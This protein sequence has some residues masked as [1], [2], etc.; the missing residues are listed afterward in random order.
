MRVF[1]YRRISRVTERTTSIE[2]QGEHCTA[3]C[4]RRGWKVVDDFSDEG[5]S[6]ATDPEDRP[7][8]ARMLARLDEV[9]AIVFYKLDRLSRST[10]AFAELMERCKA[11]GVALVSCTEPLDLSSPMGVA[12]AEIIAVFAKLER[13]MIRER[14]MDA[15]RKGLEDHKF[16]GGRFP[17]GL[18]PAPH[19]SGKGR[20]LV[21]DTEAVKN[22]RRMA[23]LV[24]AGHSASAIARKLNEDK[25]PTSRQQGATAKRAGGHEARDTY[26]RGNAVRAILRNQVQLGYRVGKNERP[27]TGSDGLPLVIWEPVL[28]WE[29]WEAVQTAIDA[30]EVTR[31]QRHDAHWLQG[32]T[33]CGVCDARLTQTVAH[34]RTGLKCARPNEERHKPAPFIRADD[35]DAWVNEQMTTVYGRMRVIENVWHSGS[36]NRQERLAVASAI[37]AMRADRKAGLY[38][39]AEDEAEYTD[40]ITS[41]LARRDVLDATPET[42]PHWETR[43]TGRTFGDV[44]ESSTLTARAALMANAGLVVRV[45]PAGGKRRPVGERARIEQEDPAA[46]ELA[47]SV[48]DDDDEPARRPVPLT[49]EQHEEIRQDL[50]DD[51]ATQEGL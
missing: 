4:D 23:S 48:A 7:A 10:L 30:V 15:R 43:D 13:A 31:T 17:Y 32:V 12:M 38:R 11:A 18:T 2:R 39:G 45:E 41:L 44:W 14:S 40:Q 8:M 20:V 36:N 50:L 1:T 6:G 5:V 25:V 37:K 46:A 21:R 26:W 42:E 28:T 35:L 51:I 22:I 47:G 3:E 49:P 9:D 33:R 29:E 16:V 19:P 27:E 24:V 34:G